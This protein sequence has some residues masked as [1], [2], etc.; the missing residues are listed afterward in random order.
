MRSR[1]PAFTLIELL[2]V[3]AIIA[4]LIGL[5]TAA[6]Q[7][8][9]WSALRTS[10]ANNLRQLGVAFANYHS[11]YKALPSGQLAGSGMP[12]ASWHTQLL[13]FVEQI[14]LA[15]R[16][17]RAFKR[18]PVLASRAHRAKATF[19]AVFAC[20]AGDRVEDPAFPLG[21]GPGA[22]GL[23]SYLGVEG[24]SL[25]HRDGCLYEDSRVRAADISDGL[26]N[27]IL[28]G[29]RPAALGPVC[30]SAW[31]TGVWGQGRGSC[32]TLLGTIEPLIL[33][34]PGC[35]QVPAGYR[36]GD[37]N[38]PCDYFHF[39]SLHEGGGHFLFADGSVRFLSYSAAPLL[40]ALGT[41]AGREPVDSPD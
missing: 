28:V 25:A 17:R 41:R 30:Y 24:T 40:P 12:G 11:V 34:P 18:T 23:T 4:V 15:E 31:Y 29:E 37:P 35:S 10:C 33:A 13:P 14:P 39:W 8:A 9:R 20:P 2:I 3:I 32:A 7:K 1:R 22:V 5:T 21:P 27:T 19:L 26:S 16:T 38:N 6:V 36:P